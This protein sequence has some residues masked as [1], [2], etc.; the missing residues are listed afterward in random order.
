MR[1]G[2]NREVGFIARVGI[3]YEVL[4]WEEKALADA[5]KDLNLSVDLLHIHSLQLLIGR[6]GL[7]ELSGIDDEIVLQRAISHTTALN[8][9][10]A[11]ESLGIR[12]INTS[13]ATATA[14]NKLWTASILARAGIKIPR[15]I[16]A[17]SEESCYKSAQLLG[18]PVVVKPIDGSWG[19]LIA[20]ARDD[21][22]LRAILEHRTYMPNPTMKVHMLQEFVKKPGRD[23]RIFVV[24]DETP[25]AIYRVSGH[26]ITNTARGGKAVAARIDAELS[27]LALKSAKL[28]G[29]E[30]A[31][32]D[33]FEDPERGYIVNEI[34]AIPEFKNTVAATGIQLHTKIVEY[35]RN[36]VRK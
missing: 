2:E 34:N 35:I 18:Y 1:T 19:R 14:M 10:L 13:N 22:E 36:Q 21:E 16:I 6:N 33:V 25:A 28:I 3:A 31:G 20:M 24:G 27:E 11:L 17:F 12:V 15:T 26:W 9:T 30:V 8:V 32:I 7:H 4:R 29:I 5:A 23:I